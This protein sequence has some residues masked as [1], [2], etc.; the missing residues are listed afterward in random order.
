MTQAIDIL[1]VLRLEDGREWGDA[2]T[3]V[4]LEDARA[5]L[6]GETPYH[7]ITRARGYSKTADLAG[8]AVALLLTLPTGA[9]CYWL[10]AD[11][12]QGKL[13]LD[14]ISGYVSRTELLHGS[15]EIQASRV[16]APATGNRLDVLA[17]DAPSSWGLRP[18]AVFVDELCQWPTTANATRLWEAV[19]SAATKVPGARMAI[20]TTAGSPHHP[21]AEVLEH[22]KGSPLWRVSETPGPP[23]WMD[24]ERLA[25]QRA[26]LPEGIY[27]Q[28]FENVWT[29]AEGAFLS[30]GR[31]TSVSRSRARNRRIRTAAPATSR[32]STWATSTIE[33]RSRWLTATAPTSCSTTCARGRARGGRRSAST[34]SRTASRRRT[35]TTG[36][37]C[38]PIRGKRSTSC[39][40]CAPE[41]SGRGSSTSRR[42]RSNGSR[43]PSFSPSTT[44]P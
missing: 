13:A 22:A 20:I 21:A 5:L 2:A 1:A 9:R 39:S 38:R 6:D 15:I 7:F 41:A 34:T 43:A 16:V 12:D 18:A 44:A 42:A 29:E 37:D 4:Q 32:V 14:S 31:S 33:A 10:A 24:P 19:S 8:A 17:A 23:P 40:A 26:R 36:S 27:A 35:M 3:R 28:L 25:E 30:P 11:Q